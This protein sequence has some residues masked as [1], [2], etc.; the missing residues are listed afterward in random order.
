MDYKISNRESTKTFKQIR[1][2]ILS[3]YSKREIW[4][5]GMWIACQ[6]GWTEI[7]QLESVRK[8]T[9]S[10]ISKNLPFKNHEQILLPRICHFCKSYFLRRSLISHCYQRPFS[11]RFWSPIP[12]SIYAYLLNLVLL[13]HTISP[14]EQLKH[15]Y[16][17]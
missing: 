2:Q 6:I 4:K 7:G 16:D 11:V 17:D 3:L 1:D 9:G 5:C 12:T 15:S 10:L 13:A 14:V 8:L